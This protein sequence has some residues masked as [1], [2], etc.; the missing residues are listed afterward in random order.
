MF[1]QHRPASADAK[2]HPPAT[3]TARTIPVP[4]RAEDLGTVRG[5]DAN[6]PRS[7]CPTRRR[8][9]RSRLP[10][11]SRTWPI[12]QGG[13]PSSRRGFFPR[14]AAGVGRIG[15]IQLA[16]GFPFAP[17]HIPTGP[18]VRNTFSSFL[19]E[20]KPFSQLYL[21]RS[22]LGHRTMADRSSKG[23]PIALRAAARGSWRGVSLTGRR[24]TTER[25]GTSAPDSKAK[26][27]TELHRLGMSQPR[28][29]LAFDAAVPAAGRAGRDA[30]PW[31]PRAHGHPARAP[32]RE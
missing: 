13:R 11:A 32:E 28:S 2:T 17:D 19:S 22:S 21:C 12:P 7:G 1:D 24:A 10:G 29:F 6:W 4:G 18:E 3:G 14:S 20:F 15:R 23:H 16:S 9:A 26:V 8:R 5:P 31:R 30:A 25:R 27:A